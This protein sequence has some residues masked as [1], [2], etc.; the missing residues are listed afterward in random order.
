MK[1]SLK[2]K[3]SE[4]C[5]ETILYSLYIIVY[6]EIKFAKDPN[7]FFSL[8]IRSPQILLRDSF[9]HR[10][11]HLFLQIKN[12]ILSDL[13]IILT[14]SIVAVDDI[15]FFSDHRLPIEDATDM[16][17]KESYLESSFRKCL[18]IIEMATEK[19]MEDLVFVLYFCMLKYGG[20]DIYID[21]TRKNRLLYKL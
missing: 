2:F 5:F 14:V 17:L 15:L 18:A 11:Y 12:K 3:E 8:K 7:M 19:C 4:Y 10:C 9:G 6:I 20:F 13:R 1:S 16:L 21:I